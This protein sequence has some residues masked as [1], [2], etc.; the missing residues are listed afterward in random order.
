MEQQELQGIITQSNLLQV[1]DPKELIRV[2]ETLQK[3]LEEQTKQLQEEKEL[4]QVTLQ[5]IGDAVITTNNFS[6][7][8]NINPM[9]GHLTGW[10]EEEAKGKL[11]SEV[12]HI[13][14]EYTSPTSSQSSRQSFGTK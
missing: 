8:V 2:I 3:E 7:V 1:L 11:L 13:I 12:F 4:A 9:A 14:N 6:Q 10:R 5:S